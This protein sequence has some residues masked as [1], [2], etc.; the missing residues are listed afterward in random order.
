MSAVF[1][2]SIISSLAATSWCNNIQAC[3]AKPSS[4]AHLDLLPDPFY[5][6]STWGRGCICLTA[7]LLIVVCLLSYSFT[8][9]NWNEDTSRR[10]Q[11]M[12]LSR[13][14]QAF[15]TGKASGKNRNFGSGVEGCGGVGWRIVNSVIRIQGECEGSV[16][17]V[18]WKLRLGIAG[19]WGL[20]TV[21]WS[22]LN[23]CHFTTTAIKEIDST[24]PMVYVL[25][26]IPL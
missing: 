16:W 1:Q 12:K 15:M 21:I 4:F 9:M 17:N 14:L 23:S 20:W 6:S 22:C 8:K 25:S 26:Q 7:T 18:P 11:W 5:T 24:T 10:F 3:F 13:R 2:E 19:H